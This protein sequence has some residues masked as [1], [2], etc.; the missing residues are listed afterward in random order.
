MII[1]IV[2][3]IIIIIVIIYIQYNNNNDNVQNRKTK[4]MRGKPI[5]IIAYFNFP[6]RNWLDSQKRTNYCKNLRIRT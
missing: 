1:I 6:N 3:I 2:I 5:L 4:G